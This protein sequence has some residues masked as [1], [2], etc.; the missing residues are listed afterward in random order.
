MRM[1]GRTTLAVAGALL[2]TA[3]SADALVL[4][5]KRSGVVVARDACKRKESP[6][7]VA[8]LGLVG[9]T[10]PAGP[11]GAA[12]MDGFGGARAYAWVDYSTVAFVAA[13]TKNFTSVTRPTNGHYC[14]T[15]VAGIDTDAVPVVVTIDH[16]RSTG[17]SDFAYQEVDRFNCSAGTFEIVTTSGGSFDN[18]ISF[19]VAV[20]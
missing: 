7:D 12:G 8:T 17:A 3:V 20:P 15:P 9:P 16:G 14:R 11:T 10:G 1:R 5:Q 4:C 6:I 13:K 18:N 19:V 2:A